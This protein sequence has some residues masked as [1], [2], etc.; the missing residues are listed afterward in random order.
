MASDESAEPLL[1][2]SAM[3]REHPA[4]GQE[5]QERQRERP[6]S[7]MGDRGEQSGRSLVTNRRQDL[8]TLTREYAVTGG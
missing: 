4:S 2:G 6:P 1:E 8:I 3:S 7:G 5:Q